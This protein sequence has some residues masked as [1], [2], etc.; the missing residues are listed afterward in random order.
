MSNLEEVMVVPKV[1]FRTEVWT[2]QS[3]GEE[4]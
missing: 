4:N 2:R 3:G 1:C